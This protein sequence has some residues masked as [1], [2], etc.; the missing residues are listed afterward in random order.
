MCPTCLAGPEEPASV[1]HRITVPE[2]KVLE[3]FQVEKELIGDEEM[4]RSE[5]K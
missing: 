4:V 5:T 1:H 2:I 3:D